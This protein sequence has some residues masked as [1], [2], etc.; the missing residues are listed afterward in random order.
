MRVFHTYWTMIRKTRMDRLFLSFLVFFC[1]DCIFIYLCDPGI[2]T[3]GDALWIGFNVATTIGLGDMT[4]TSPLARILVSLIGLYGIVIAAVIPGLIA[5]HYLDATRKERDET[6]KAHA[7]QLFEQGGLSERQKRTAKRLFSKGWNPMKRASLFALIVKRTKTIRFLLALAAVFVFCS[8][9]LWQIDPVFGSWSNA[10]WYCFMVVTTT[11]FGDFAPTTLMARLVSVFLG[12]Y[13]VIAMG[14]LC[15]VG[16][17]WL[18]ERVQTLQGRS[19]TLMIHQLEHLGE[20]DD[21]Q[22]EALR[23]YA[24]E[25]ADRLSMPLAQSLIML[26]KQSDSSDTASA[27]AHT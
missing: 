3:F 7:R 16:A 2:K 11:G 6:L 18:F 12:V 17:S 14:F 25:H 22:L 27:S 13:G 1:V 24:N 5:S 15:G 26:K 21:D 19:S 4:L 9:V 8:L 10:L 23:D 20:L